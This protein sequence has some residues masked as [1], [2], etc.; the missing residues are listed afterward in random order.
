MK[1]KYKLILQSLILLIVLTL[2]VLYIKNN[3]IDFK[4]LNI[5]NPLYII[6]TLLI[7]PFALFFGG[8]LQRNILLAFKIRLK[9]IEYFGL[10]V[11]T[12]F[13]NTITPFK[14]GYL[15][16]AMYLKKR[17]TF[18]YGQYISMLAGMQVISILLSCLCGLI[19]ISVISIDKNI[20][21]GIVIGIYSF[22]LL[23]SMLIIFFPLY[24]MLPKNPSNNYI[25]EKLNSIACGWNVVRENV[26]VL[27]SCLMI[28]FL[29]LIISCLTSM[30]TLYILG[31]K[32]DFFQSLFL[33]T[34][35]NLSGFIQIT[36]A[37]L[38]ITEAIVMFT[39]SIINITPAQALSA[40]VITRF[41]NL[42]ILLILSPIFSF[43]L[44]RKY[45]LLKDVE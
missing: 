1:K 18:S 10:T 31:V 13:Y 44:F 40:S 16:K 37:G 33:N 43:I 32:I 29:Q 34:F 25:L 8:L 22:F 6:I 14:A 20:Y 5:E 4:S 41:T 28:L 21:G 39:G 15:V 30:S 26:K 11:I 19:S 7:T 9:S 24:K 23:M 45:N 2:L 3:I 35:V 36:P 12:N 42:L 27:I 17:H 38:G